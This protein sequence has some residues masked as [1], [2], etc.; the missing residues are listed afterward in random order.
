[1]DTSETVIGL[2]ELREQYEGEWVGGE[3]V[4]RNPDHSP[5]KL[6]IVA[7]AG[8]LAGVL[9]QLEGM[10]EACVLYAGDVIPDDAHGLI[11]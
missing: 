7:R 2:A 5:K 10:P 4:E 6:R 8:D 9:R 1:M 11:L 3:V